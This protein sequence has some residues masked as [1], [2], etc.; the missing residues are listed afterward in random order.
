MNACQSAPKRPGLGKSRFIRLLF[1]ISV[2]LTVALSAYR[3][4]IHLMN[5]DG[6]M[7]AYPGGYRFRVFIAPFMLLGFEL[8]FWF[9]FYRHSRPPS[10]IFAGMMGGYILLMIVLVNTLVAEVY[11]R[12]L[13]ATMLW[14]Y[15][16]AGIGH[17][18]FAFFGREGRY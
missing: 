17:L 13:P 15:T 7:D 18:V 16:I 11:D 4:I 3:I 2:W 14:L 1:V 5:V 10:R 12:A 8:F 6:I 9:R